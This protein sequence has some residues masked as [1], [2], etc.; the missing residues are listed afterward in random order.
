VIQR[1]IRHKQWKKDH[2]KG[3]HGLTSKEGLGVEVFAPHDEAAHQLEGGGVAGGHCYG[4]FER[5]KLSV[6]FGS[7]PFM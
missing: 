2:Q 1:G 4:I 3:C 7:V 5:R 6:W